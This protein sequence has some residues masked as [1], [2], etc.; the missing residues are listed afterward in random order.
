MDTLANSIPKQGQALA[1]KATDKA[2]QVLGEAVPILKSTANQARAIGRQGIDAVTDAVSQARDVASDA[3][4]S[5]IAYTKKNPAT[6]LAI[7]AATGV[8]LYAAIKVYMSRRD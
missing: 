6:A 5:I 2:N 4:D 3:S 1:D 7:A 8:V